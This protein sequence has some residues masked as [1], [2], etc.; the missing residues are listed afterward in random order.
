MKIQQNAYHLTRQVPIMA[1]ERLGSIPHD[2]YIMDQPFQANVANEPEP[3]PTEKLEFDGGVPVFADN[4]VLD[5]ATGK[6]QF[7]NKVEFVEAFP[8]KALPSGLS[9]AAGSI[10]GSVVAGLVTSGPSS[11]AVAGA[12][13]LA[14]FSLGALN[15]ARDK[16]TVVDTQVPVYK[17]ELV[18]Y[19]HQVM[20]GALLSRAC[21]EGQDSSKGSGKLHYYVPDTRKT[22][23]GRMAVQEIRHTAWKTESLAGVGFIAGLASGFLIG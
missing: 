2:A 10:L 8:Q 14:A 19:H 3:L 12:S 21:K 23:V 15:G 1:R 20:D 18:G 17:T 4:P 11:L 7:K 22:E 13:A 16:I 6:V 5:P 9:A